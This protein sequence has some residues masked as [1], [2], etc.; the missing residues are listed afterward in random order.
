MKKKIMALFLV[1]VLALGISSTALAGETAS[2]KHTCT[3]GDWQFLGT[4]QDPP[5]SLSY[6][7]TYVTIQYRSCTVC[8]NSQI[9]E[10]K[11]NMKHT[12]VWVGDK[13]TCQRCG[14]EIGFAR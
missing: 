8:G 1:F 9:R 13:G 10:Q 2:T 7:F 6:C 12:F 3:Y 5:P 11:Q 14:W 4:R